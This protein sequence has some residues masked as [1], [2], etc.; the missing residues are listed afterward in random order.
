MCIRDRYYSTSMKCIS[1]KE[2]QENIFLQKRNMSELTQTLKMNSSN[3]EAIQHYKNTLPDDREILKRE[4]LL[5]I[6]ILL[7]KSLTIIKKQV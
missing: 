1:S 3:K 2:K 6:L 4:L 7:S 5:P